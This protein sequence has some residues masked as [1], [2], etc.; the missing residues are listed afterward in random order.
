MTTGTASTQA[1]EFIVEQ[2]IASLDEFVDMVLP[3]VTTGVI[4]VA[5]VAA[6]A[7]V[8][9]VTAGISLWGRGRGSVVHI[10]PPTDE[11]GRSP[12][13]AVRFWRETATA[14]AAPWWSPARRSLTI[15]VTVTAGSVAIALH[16]PDAVS[17]TRIGHTVRSAWPGATT[18]ITEPA[19]PRTSHP[20]AVVARHLVPR[21]PTPRSTDTDDP[22]RRVADHAN[23]ADT[24]ETCRV[25]LVVALARLGQVRQA[26]GITEERP[27]LRSVGA[28]IRAELPTLT[29]LWHGTP[30][31]GG[32][33]TRHPTGPADRSS[34]HTR[35]PGWVEDRPLWRITLTAICT[36]DQHPQH[37]QPDQL[38]PEP[39]RLDPEPERLAARGAAELASAFAAFRSNT[40]LRSHRAR[41]RTADPLPHGRH[42][43]SGRFG[44]LVTNSE[45]AGLAY[46]PHPTRDGTTVYPTATPEALV[47][48]S[49]ITL[50]DPIAA[51]D[52]TRPAPGER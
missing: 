44:F 22:L 9:W 51:D 35:R 33:A 11:N 28:A 2:A 39:E 1:A 29:Q 8:G 50:A 7:F 45:L 13:G 41:A 12:D 18:R 32:R 6:L 36:I 21:D 26:A 4:V 52:G 49:P 17:A 24:R 48:S 38:D 47:R 5:A 46:L 30:T 34:D 37:P 42:T 14:L 25:V 40:G 43:P 31:P 15:E 10:T 20:T 27:S 23:Y 16:V 19:T 3:W